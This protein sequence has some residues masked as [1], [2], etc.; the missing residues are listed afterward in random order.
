MDIAQRT[1]LYFVATD[2]PEINIQRV[3]NRVEERSHDV[4]KDKIPTL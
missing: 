3:A 2:S 4:P 1:Y